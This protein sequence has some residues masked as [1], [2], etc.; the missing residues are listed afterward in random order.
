[1]QGTDLSRWLVANLGSCHHRYVLL[2][3]V[4]GELEG[5]RGAWGYVSGGMG[6][7]SQAI[8]RAA[9]ARGAHI[10]SEKVRGA[11]GPACRHWECS[12]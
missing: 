12:W 10:F 5:R 1:M 6:A 11:W 2:H 8:A 7:L 4:M 9:A 3:H